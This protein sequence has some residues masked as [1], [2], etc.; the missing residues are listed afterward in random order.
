[1]YVCVMY[2]YIL[3]CLL[4]LNTLIYCNTRRRTDT[5][6][7]ERERSQRVGVLARCPYSR[8]YRRARSTHINKPRLCFGAV[9]TSR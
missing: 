8:T 7:R 5:R 4:I 2:I 6:E 9:I 3:E 1:M